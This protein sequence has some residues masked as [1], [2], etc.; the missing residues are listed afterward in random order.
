MTKNFTKNF[1]PNFLLPEIKRLNEY[2][3][4]NFNRQFTIFELAFMLDLPSSMVRACCLN[5][6][7]AIHK[8]TRPSIKDY[9][10]DLKFNFVSKAF[11]DRVKYEWNIILEPIE[12]K[13]ERDVSKLP[14]NNYFYGL[15]LK[16]ESPS[17]KHLIGRK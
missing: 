12:E 8:T 2:A 3:N 5:H 9:H 4:A 7:I 1:H 16:N 10:H 11:K 14:L 6:N 15:R 17:Y 13:K